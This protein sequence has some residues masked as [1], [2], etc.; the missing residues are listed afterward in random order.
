[1]P[2]TSIYIGLSRQALDLLD[3]IAERGLWGRT[4]EEVAARLVDEGLQ[5][6]AQPVTFGVAIEKQGGR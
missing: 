6:F 4:S 5:R 1:M 2:N 3:Q